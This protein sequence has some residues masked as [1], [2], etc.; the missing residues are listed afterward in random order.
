MKQCA[1]Y[2]MESNTYL[3][4]CICVVYEPTSV[5]IETDHLQSPFVLALIKTSSDLSEVRTADDLR[6]T[7]LFDSDKPVLLRI[8]SE[9]LLGMFGDS[10]CD[11]EAQRMAS[12]REIDHVG[13][14]VYVHLPQEAQG[15]GLFYKAQELQIQVTGI[16][17]DGNY[18]GSKDISEAA[19]HLLGSGQPLEKRQYSSLVRLF[20]LVGLDRY[21]YHLISDSPDKAAALQTQLRIN[22]VALHEAKRPVTLENAAEYLA[23]L[24]KKYSLSDQEL[25]D[26]YLAI[27]AAEEIPG[28]ILSLLRYLQEDIALGHPFKANL[29]LLDKI[30]GIGEQRGVQYEYVNDMPLLKDIESYDEYQVELKI[31]TTDDVN[32]LFDAGILKA[33][34]SLRYEENHFYNLAYFRD[35]PARSLKIRN[36]YRLTDRSRP[37]ESKF[38]Y[39]LPLGE[40]FYRIKSLV[41][42][43]DEI[44]RLLVAALR[45]YERHLQPVLTHNVITIEPEVTVL[46]KRYNRELRTLSVMGPERRVCDFVN[47]VRRSVSAEEIDDPS[48]FRYLNRSLSIDFVLSE[49]Q[50]EEVSLFRAYY[51]G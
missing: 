7:Q 21:A 41:M 15:N 25:E 30:S 4:H 45:D 26:I 12:L 6:G 10:H 27:S 37:V 16:D 43:D 40:K 11:C 38:I 34:D 24:Y 47:T 1:I 29:Q 39:K 50:D 19:A 18:V 35:V 32:K 3:G 51:M 13:Q 49:L 22:V 42:D 46:I 20:A 44:A 28:R 33:M 14:G 2:R 36:A 23:K 8:G 5:E 9:C 17:P 31:T 48:N